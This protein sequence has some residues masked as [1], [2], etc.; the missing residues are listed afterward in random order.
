MTRSIPPSVLYRYPGIFTD[1]ELNSQQNI[2]ALKISMFD[3]K[4]EK[5]PGHFAQVVRNKKVIERY[6]DWENFE[7]NQRIATKTQILDFEKMIN[8][9]YAEIFKQ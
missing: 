2:K 1:A 3:M 7:R 4:L 9:K 5:Q 8:A 6:R